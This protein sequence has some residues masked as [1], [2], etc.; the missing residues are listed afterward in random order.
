M[1]NRAGSVLRLATP[2]KAWLQRFALSFVVSATVALMLL[3]KA[4]VVLLEKARIA[5]TDAVAPILDAASR[6]VAT[7]VDAM[8]QLQELNAIRAENAVLRQENRRRS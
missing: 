6:P 7:V 4:D 8:E 1:N 3:A 2:A 5:A